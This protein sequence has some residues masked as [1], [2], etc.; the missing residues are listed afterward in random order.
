MN[1]KEYVSRRDVFFPERLLFKYA[2]AESI[3][4]ITFGVFMKFRY[5]SMYIM[6]S[7]DLHDDQPKHS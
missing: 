5:K 3:S 7:F 4:L 1:R 6:S 2:G